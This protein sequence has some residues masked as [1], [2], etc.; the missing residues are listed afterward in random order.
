MKITVNQLRRIIKEEILS[1]LNEVVSVDL[2]TETIMK[3][4]Q[5]TVDYQKRNRRSLGSVIQAIE[6]GDWKYDGMLKDFEALK[7]RGEIVGDPKEE[8]I[9][10][11]K[12][13]W[14]SPQ[15]ASYERSEREPDPEGWRSSPGAIYSR[16]QKAKKKFYGR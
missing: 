12:E 15:P 11:I 9:S 5:G 10:K 3:N 13:L 14:D 4:L 8:L 1:T 2:P 16:E 6:S 7:R